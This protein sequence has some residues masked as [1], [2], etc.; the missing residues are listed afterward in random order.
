[1]KKI[2]WIAFKSLLNKEVMRFT[3]IWIQT[4]MPPIITMTLYFLIFGN[5][6]G[7]HINNIMGYSYLQF[8]VP[9]IIMMAVI[10]NSYANV[11]F[12]F[13]SARLQKSIEEL[14]V[15][16]VPTHI[17]IAGYVGGGIIRGISVG[18]LITIAS[19]FFVP[20]HVHSW[21]IIILTLILTSLMFSLAGLLNGLFANDFDEISIIP[22]FI[23]TPL[24]YLS[25]VFYSITTLPP[26]WQKISK[27]NP[28]IYMINGFRFGFIGIT[29]VSVHYILI[30]LLFFNIF[31]Y[32]LVWWLIEKGYGLKS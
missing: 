10:S 22:T 12:S 4:L 29:D 25:G 32:L 20:L 27:L 2:Y 7:V 15:A 8:I 18:L 3:R 1:M 31:F 23:I 26:F 28:V 21:I 6:I 24:T 14:L 13:F 9:G 19:F 5:I 16:P 30:V 11:A 17:I